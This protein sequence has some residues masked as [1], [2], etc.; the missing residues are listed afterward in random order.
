VPLAGAGPW[1]RPPLRID[2]GPSTSPEVFGRGD[3]IR[4]CDLLV[5]NQALY[6]AKLR[7]EIEPALW[8][9]SLRRQAAIRGS[10]GKRGSETGKRMANEPRMSRIGTAGIKRHAVSSIRVPSVSSVANPSPAPPISPPLSRD[11]AVHFTTET[12]RAQRGECAGSSHRAVRRNE[13]AVRPLCLGGFHC[14]VPAQGAAVR[15]QVSHHP[16]E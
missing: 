14:I 5:P 2:H 10:G 11:D 13:V 15:S 12:P 1:A 3:R 6:Q 9:H 8:G 4:T 16:A 7:P